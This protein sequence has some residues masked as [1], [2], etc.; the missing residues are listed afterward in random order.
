MVKCK[1]VQIGPSELKY[2]GRWGVLKPAR[3]LFV[4]YEAA[5]GAVY[6]IDLQIGKEPEL[7]QSMA[8]WLAKSKGLEC[9]EELPTGL[10]L[11][12]R[13]DNIARATVRHFRADILPFLKGSEYADFFERENYY[14]GLFKAEESK[15][16][17]DENPWDDSSVM[18]RQFIALDDGRVII[19]SYW[20]E[21]GEYFLDYDVPKDDLGEMDQ[22]TLIKYLEVQ[23]LSIKAIMKDKVTDF[24]DKEYC[25]RVQVAM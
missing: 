20:S 19:S 13:N 8:E 18:S 3:S 15:D 17:N 2:K 10:Y 4:G 14:C 24:L 9:E 25:Y 11:S 5:D 23:G 1:S 21:Y 12:L 6:H 22:D 16:D 7:M